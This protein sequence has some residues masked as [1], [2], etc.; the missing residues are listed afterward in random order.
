MELSTKSCEF[1]VVWAIWCF[2]PFRRGGMSIRCTDVVTKARLSIAADNSTSRKSCP[3][4]Q[5]DLQSCFTFAFSNRQL[6]LVAYRISHIGPVHFNE[7]VSFQIKICGVRE[8]AD[9]EAVS[10]SGADAIGWNFF[11][12]SC[13]FLDPENA[14][15]L[16]IASKA[17]ELGLSQVGVFVNHPIERI[18]AISARLGIDAVQLHGDESPEFAM[19]LK[20]AGVRQLIRAIK[21]PVESLTVASI[22]KHVEPW[23]STGAHLL[24]DSDG[25][26][27]HGGTGKTLDWTVVRDWALRSEVRSDLCRWFE[28]RKYCHCDRAASPKCGHASGVETRAKNQH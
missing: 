15:T 8:I 12:P 18:L 3:A 17:A 24:L 25:G 2:A 28:S 26:R 11:P 14:S 6:V 7:I 1:W 23:I 20:E 5:C 10:Q 4:M 19:Q 13:R 9:V 16:Q 22:T 21:L 27:Q